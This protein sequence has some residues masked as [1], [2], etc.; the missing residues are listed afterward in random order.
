MHASGTPVSSLPLY[1]GPFCFDPRKTLVISK[2]AFNDVVRNTLKASKKYCKPQHLVQF[3]L[4]RDLVEQ[5]H[6]LIILLTGTSG[7]G[8]STLASLLAE[9]LGINTVIST[10]HI[11]HMLRDSVSEEECPELFMSTYE[12]HTAV[13]DNLPHSKKVRA[14]YKSQCAIVTEKLA[15]IISNFYKQKISVVIEGVHLIMSFVVKLARQ[16]PCVVPFLVYISNENKHR[17]RFAVRSKF[18]SLQPESNRYVKNFGNIRVIQKYLSQKAKRHLIPRIDNTNIDRSIAAIHSILLRCIR[19]IAAERPLFDKNLEKAILMHREY[20]DAQAFAWSA[21]HMKEVVC[22]CKN[23]H[24]L[25]LTPLFKFFST[26]FSF[27]ILRFLPVTRDKDAKYT[28]ST[29]FQGYPD[30][31]AQKR[32]VSKTVQFK[33]SARQ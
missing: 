11:R 3:H 23:L 21:K 33:Q 12:T 27:S 5:R 30:E 9:R 29:Q 17:E 20:E 7:T 31:G 25:L 1:F 2:S 28:A 19:H 13:S 10:D 32:I 14:G 18:H 26:L 24:P 4:S 22:S 15:Y 8:K 16:Y 6:G